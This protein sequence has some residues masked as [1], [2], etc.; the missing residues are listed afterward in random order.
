MVLSSVVMVM[1]A[2]VATTV[3]FGLSF[4]YCSVVAMVAPFL[5]V[6]DADVTSVANTGL[7]GHTKKECNIALLFYILCYYS[8]ANTT[9]VSITAHGTI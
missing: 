5:A 1:V 2:D 7:N 6:T 9:S 3:V 4:Y 8:P